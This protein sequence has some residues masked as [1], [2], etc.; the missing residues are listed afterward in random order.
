[1]MGNDI[2]TNQINPG[3]FIGGNRLK[4]GKGSFISYNN[5]FDLSDDITIGN[6]VHIAMRCLFITSLHEMG[7]KDRRAGKI[8]HKPISIGDGCW[9]GGNVTILPGVKIGKGTII[10]AGAVVTKNCESNSLYAGV[11]AHKIK[12]LE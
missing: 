6:N 12:N 1:M 10:A 3:C 5:F 8:E 4:V 11:P 9:I 2:K 7:D